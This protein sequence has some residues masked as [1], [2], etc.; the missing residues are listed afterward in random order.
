MHEASYFSA[1]FCLRI[2]PVVALCFVMMSCEDATAPDPVVTG[3]PA[4][5]RLS[6]SSND[7]LGQLA[8]DMETM[9][10]WTL[11]DFPD[12]RGRTNVVGLLQSLKG[13]LTAG[14][15]EACQEDV[16]TIRNFLGTL[17]ENEQV[18]L[19]GIGV[20]LDVIENALDKS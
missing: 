18:E 2:V 11:V 4:A 6:A 13:H 10:D 8:S 14:K 17:T 1:R 5:L 12:A 15:I 7:Q 9:T 3:A 16:N 19:G 20:T